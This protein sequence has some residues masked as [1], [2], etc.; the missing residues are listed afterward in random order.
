M[1]EIELFGLFM[2][3]LLVLSILAFLPYWLTRWVFQRLGVYHWVWHP[4]LFD[5][6][7]YVI[8]LGLINTLLSS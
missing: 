7:L 4:A 8:L 6:A 5:T 2:P 1:M 3:Q